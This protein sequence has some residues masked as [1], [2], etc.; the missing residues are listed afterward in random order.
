MVVRADKEVRNTFTKKER[1][2]NESVIK[3]LFSK[4]SSFYFGPIKV[5]YLKS[6]L[7][8]SKEHQ[9]L[10]TV[11]KR[12]FKRA[13]DR[14]IL[15]RRMR[16]AYRLNKSTLPDPLKQILI[17]AYIYVGKEIVPYSI[18]ETKLIASIQRLNKELQID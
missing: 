16:E 15:K 6:N 11:P 17:I 13:V 8:E 14:N 18:L 9:V 7:P 4:G 3:E 5:I 1:L 2:H 12:L 10:F